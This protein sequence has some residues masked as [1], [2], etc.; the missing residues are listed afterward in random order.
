[1]NSEFE[2]VLEQ[3]KEASASSPKVFVAVAVVFLLLG[4]L[5]LCLDVVSPE[6]SRVAAL[7]GACFGIVAMAFVAY[8]RSAQSKLNVEIVKTIR[9]LRAKSEKGE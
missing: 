4:I 3:E 9:D 7:C 5:L 1:M 2:K 8:L 6:A